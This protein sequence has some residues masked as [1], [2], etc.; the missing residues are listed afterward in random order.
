MSGARESAH[1]AP[2]PGDEAQPGATM[3]AVSDAIVRLMK[4]H[5]GKGPTSVKT[6]LLGDAVVV[7]TAG[8]M[9]K[10]EHTLTDLGHEEAVI[11]QR[12]VFKQAMT[13]RFR[14]VVAGAT[15]REVVAVMS[16][17][18]VDPDYACETFVLAPERD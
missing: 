16:A 18:H 7:L 11:E 6:H 1:D 17:T 9:T 14:D 3:L 5:Y 2:A 8:G 10:V 13:D 12:R 15:G 4:E